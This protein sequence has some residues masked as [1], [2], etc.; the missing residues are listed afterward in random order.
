M[1]EAV[2]KFACE[3]GVVAKAT[4]VGDLAQGLVTW[5]AR[6]PRHAWRA[7]SHRSG[8]RKAALPAPLL[9]RLQSDRAALRKLK[10][11]LRKAAER[12]VEGLQCGHQ[13]PTLHVFCRS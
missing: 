13:W 9:A 5:I 8:R 4:G 7:R 12:S 10:A 3:M 6:P 1:T 2:A 11:L